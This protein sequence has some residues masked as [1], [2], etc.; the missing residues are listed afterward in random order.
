MSNVRSQTNPVVAHELPLRGAGVKA[1]GK[2]GGAMA[3]RDQLLSLIERQ[4]LFAQSKD[5]ADRTKPVVGVRRT[6]NAGSSSAIQIQIGQCLHK[7][8]DG[9]TQNMRWP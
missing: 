2:D 9:A 1:T 6:T 4:I 7:A 5:A 8:G 3:T